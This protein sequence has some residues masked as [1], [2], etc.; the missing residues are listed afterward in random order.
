[1]LSYYHQCKINE[2]TQSKFV[3]SANGRLWLVAEVNQYVLIPITNHHSTTTLAAL[4]S[5]D[6]LT[7]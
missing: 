6:V 3:T 1:V 7:T 2:I 4:L 5:E